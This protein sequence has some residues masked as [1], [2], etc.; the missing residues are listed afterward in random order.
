MAAIAIPTEPDQFDAAVVQA[1]LATKYPDVRVDAVALVDAAM[2]SDDE[3]RVS[4]AGRVT[5]DVDYA[6][7]PDALPTRVTIKIAKPGLGGIPLYDNEVNVYKNLGWLTTP[8]ENYVTFW[9]GV[10][11]CA[12]GSD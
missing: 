4:T 8:V 9:R 12:Q 7:N 10:L 1:L 2:D 11:L 6:G 5:V 3:N